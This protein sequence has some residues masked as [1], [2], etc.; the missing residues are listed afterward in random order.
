M[1][2][3][4]ILFF[5]GEVTDTLPEIHADKEGLRVHADGSYGYV[6]GTYTVKDFRRSMRERI[7]NAKRWP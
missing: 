1:K 2:R 4:R 6:F 3:Y 5:I 7:R